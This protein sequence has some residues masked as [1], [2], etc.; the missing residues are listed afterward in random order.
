MSKAGDIALVLIDTIIQMSD[1]AEQAGGATSIVGIS[2]L[3]KMQT[4]IQKNKKR[5]IQAIK[6][7]MSIP[8]GSEH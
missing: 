4:S 7:D 3:H 1:E 8:E 5:I 2:L 6:Q